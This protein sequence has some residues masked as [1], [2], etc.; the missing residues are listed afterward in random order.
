MLIDSKQH[1]RSCCEWEARSP[2]ANGS[3]RAGSNSSKVNS[4]DT[5][6]RQTIEI[7][8]CL[9][10]YLHWWHTIAQLPSN[11]ARSPSYKAVSIMSLYCPM[12]LKNSQ[13]QLG[14][15]RASVLIS[16]RGETPYLPEAKEPPPHGDGSNPSLLLENNGKSFPPHTAGLGNFCNARYWY[17][18]KG[19]EQDWEAVNL[20][21]YLLII[22]MVRNESYNSFKG[23]QDLPRGSPFVDKAASK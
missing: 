11:T 5:Q 1:N 13:W 22:F 19:L 18:R 4:G 12:A 8:W 9:V 10:F 7:L 17:C 6:Q 2:P 21:H 14:M 16:A 20:S 3:F 15:L 23:K